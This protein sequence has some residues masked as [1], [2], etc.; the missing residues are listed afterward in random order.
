VSRIAEYQTVE[1]TTALSLPC[2]V[3]NTGQPGAFARARRHAKRKISKW[4]SI[5]YN[6]SK[7][8]FL[9]VGNYRFSIPVHTDDYCISW[10]GVI[11]FG[12]GK[13]R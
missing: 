1:A 3:G 2:S 9:K 11:G 6:I 7:C 13:K 8:H 4:A 5:F 10:V 12:G